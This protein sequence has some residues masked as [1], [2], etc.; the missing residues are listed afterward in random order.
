[1]L[2]PDWQSWCTSDGRSGTTLEGR[3][4][5]GSAMRLANQTTATLV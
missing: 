1:M 2:A 3:N 5:G 4:E